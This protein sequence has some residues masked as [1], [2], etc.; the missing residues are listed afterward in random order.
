MAKTPSGT[1]ACSTRG[2]PALPGSV[3]SGVGG[4][5][6]VPVAPKAAA[7]VRPKR[8]TKDI[9]RYFLEPFIIFALSSVPARNSRPSPSLHRNIAPDPV[10]LVPPL[11][12]VPVDQFPFPASRQPGRGGRGRR[13][14][15]IV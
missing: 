1:N 12:P 2:V 8:R 3:W 10:I 14:G 4:G 13:H 5:A 9:A 15:G 11:F 7:G 6:L